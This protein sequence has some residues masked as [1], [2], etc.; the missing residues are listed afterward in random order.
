M[1]NFSAL[2]E[3]NLIKLSIIRETAILYIPW[4]SP[5]MLKKTNNSVKSQRR[6]D[7]RRNIYSFISLR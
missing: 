3:G 7:L 2:S 6:Q 1:S 4:E 5:K